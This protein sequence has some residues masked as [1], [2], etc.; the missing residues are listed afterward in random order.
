MKATDIQFIVIHCSAGFGGRESIERFWRES[1]GW[2]SP[3]YARLIEL[4]GKTHKLSD[5]DKQTNGVRSYNDKAIHI[6]Y[7]GGVE[8]VDG[9]YVAKDTRT[10]EQKEAIHEA[11][12]EA[13]EWLADNG[14]DITKDLSVVGH[15]DFSP[16]QDGDGVIESW[17]RIKECPSFDVMKELNRFYSSPDR[18]RKLPTTK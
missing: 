12:Q 14:K 17:E 16:D 8:K 7:I 6:C 3:G 11:I 5:F 4:D 18:Y 9:K 15:R 13:I 1:L 2:R 10:P